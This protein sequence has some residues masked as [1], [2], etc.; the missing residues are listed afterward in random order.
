MRLS[1][2]PSSALGTWNIELPSF[3]QTKATHLSRTAS[4]LL[5]VSWLAAHTSSSVAHCKQNSCKCSSMLL[6][7]ISPAVVFPTC[8]HCSLDLHLLFVTCTPGSLFVLLV[9]ST[10]GVL[11]TFTPACA[12]AKVAT[13]IRGLCLPQAKKP[14]LR[15]EPSCRPE[16]Y[17]VSAVDQ[18][19]LTGSN[20]TVV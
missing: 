10:P 18:V 3:T 20:I 12:A 4:H 11:R 6:P 8:Q 15:G 13:L 7:Y 16:R 9:A 14:C 1:A 19:W 17:S 2:L 5:D